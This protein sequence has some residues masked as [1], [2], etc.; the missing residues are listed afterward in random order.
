MEWYYQKDGDR[1]G[2]VS[3]DSFREAVVTGDVMSDTLVWNENMTEWQPYADIDAVIDPPTPPAEPAPPEPVE[4][5]GDDSVVCREC[6]CVRSPTV[7]IPFENRWICADCKETFFQK[8]REGVA[9]E[10]EGVQWEPTGGATPN[11]EIATAARDC[12]RGKLV[13]TYGILLLYGLCQFYRMVPYLNSLLKIFLKPP[14]VV[15]LARYFLCLTDRD[16]KEE[17]VNIFSGFSKYGTCLGAMVLRGLSIYVLPLALFLVAV[18]SIGAL[19]GSNLK[20]VFFGLIFVAALIFIFMWFSLF[21]VEWVIAADEE[22]GVIDAISQAWRMINGHRFKLFALCLRYFWLPILLGAAM[23]VTVIGAVYNDYDGNDTAILLFI[24]GIL[25]IGAFFY[26]IV[27]L[28][29]PYYFSAV[30]I[31]FR[32]IHKPEYE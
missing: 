18:F 26:L 9:L 24:G 4:L 2:P 17:L 10:E 21:F 28:I 29:L 23:M 15:G 14:F 27:F 6:G 11:G 20:Y 7:M 32:D 3:D 30:A 16:D 13:T 5:P 1:V 8:I 25:A 31:F 19:D 12:L 22:L